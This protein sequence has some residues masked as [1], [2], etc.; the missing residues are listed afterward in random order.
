VKRHPAQH[1]AVTT[2]P[3]KTKKMTVTKIQE[4]RRLLA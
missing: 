2:L 3:G 1:G 4:I